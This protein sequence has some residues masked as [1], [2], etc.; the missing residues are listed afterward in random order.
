MRPHHDARMSDRSESPCGSPGRDPARC[1]PQ[2]CP[3]ARRAP[4]AAVGAD[5]ARSSGGGSCSRCVVSSRC[6]RSG[7][8][9]ANDYSDGV[10]GTDDVRVGPMR[11]V[12]VGL[13]SPAARSSGRRCSAF[14]V[15]AVAGLVLA[16]RH[17][18]GGCSPSARRRSL[19]GVGLHR[20]PEAVR[21]P[22]PRRGVRVRVL[23]AA[24]PRPGT[25][26]VGDRGRPGLSAVH[27]R[28]GRVAWPARC[29]WSTTCATSRPTRAVGK[30]TLAVR[31]GD[32]ATRWLY[33]AL[34]AAAPVAA[35]VRRSPA[36]GG[37]RCCWPLAVPWRSCR[38]GRPRRGRRAATSSRC[39]GDDRRACSSLSGCC[40]DRR[41]GSSAERRRPWRRQPTSADAVVGGRQR[42][43]S[44]LRRTRGRRRG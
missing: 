43:C 16:R 31:L 7:V 10:R 40:S 6:C 41:A 9:Y 30:R 12:A 35:R 23:R 19:A 27:G 44:A 33:V 42:G 3:V 36:R 15:A 18:A 28:A 14:G 5:G 22:R 13:A 21:L 38:C 37:D 26:Y 17:V 11:L 39:S 24:S 29:W 32:R 8:N 25:T 4:A 1:R 20:R 2:S 34:V